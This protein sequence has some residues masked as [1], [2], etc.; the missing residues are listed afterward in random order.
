MDTLSIARDVEIAG[1]EREKAEAIAAAIWCSHEHAATKAGLEPLA[2]KAELTPLAT[3]ADLEPLATKAE[4]ALCATK[5]D[6]AG[7]E[8]RLT[9]RF[10]GFGI[11]LAGVV[12]ASVRL[13]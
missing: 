13:L 7:L 12:V 3:K 2:T 1:F 9:N 11:A 10:C 6:L 8:T 5:A 4:L